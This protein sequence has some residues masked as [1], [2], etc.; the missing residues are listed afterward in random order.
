M[1][2][3]NKIIED[4]EFRTTIEKYDDI[5]EH[6]KDAKP[7]IENGEL[8]AELQRDT[9]VEEISDVT[10]DMVELEE[11]L[12][13]AFDINKIMAES[14]MSKEDIELVK[15]VIVDEDG[16]LNM[17]MKSIL[18]ATSKMAIMEIFKENEDFKRLLPYLYQTTPCEILTEYDIKIDDIMYYLKDDFKMLYDTAYGDTEYKL[19]IIDAG[20]IHMAMESIK[21][22]KDGVDIKLDLL[23]SFFTIIKQLENT[24]VD[25]YNDLLKEEAY[26][27]A[28][29][30]I[31][32]YNIDTVTKFHKNIHTIKDKS[33]LPRFKQSFFEKLIKRNSKTPLG[34]QTSFS[35][36]IDDL[37]SLATLA[38]ERV[39][40]GINKDF[41]DHVQNINNNEYIVGQEKKDA[42]TY[43]I[44]KVISDIYNNKKTRWTI[45]NL[46]KQIY[47]TNLDKCYLFAKLL[48]LCEMTLK[49]ENNEIIDIE[50]IKEYNR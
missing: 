39:N 25:N 24:I 15:K 33:Y 19:Y 8:V 20:K 45:T 13:D 41:Y 28:I 11:N 9:L 44:G 50:D 17:D 36:L 38:Y 34:L 21:L 32:P 48:W 29:D 26:V 14:D 46:E 40:V 30:L 1:S 12:K 4:I 10:K 31:I 18:G 3:D 27:T 22:E 23:Y 16:N 49:L 7:I 47:S 6:M 35:E 37:G 2:E 5:P 42:I 43:S